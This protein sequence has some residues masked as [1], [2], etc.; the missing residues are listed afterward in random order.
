MFVRRKGDYA[1]R[2]VANWFIEKSNADPE[3]DPK[4]PL[5]IMKLAY[6]SHAWMLGIYG[7]PLVS[8]KVRAW[9]YGPVINEL[10]HDMKQWRDRPIVELLEGDVRPDF[11]TK[12][13]DVL[14]QVYDI[15]GPLGGLELSSLTHIP[16]SPWFVTRV[17]KFEGA[18]I[19]DELIR[20]YYG[21][22][23]IRE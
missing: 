17:K 20:E 9:K 4:T 19:S 2:S 23:T 14:Q 22:R 13:L 21:Q 18:T 3:Q 12:A 8:E 11:D 16:E 10:Y 6:F 1:A 5:E 7:N 15:Y